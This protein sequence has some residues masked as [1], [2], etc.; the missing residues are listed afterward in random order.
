[1]CERTSW[2][3][4]HGRNFHSKFRVCRFCAIVSF[5]SV[6]HV[7]WRVWYGLKRQFSTWRRSRDPDT[8]ATWT[9]TWSV[10]AG[11]ETRTC[12]WT[13]ACAGWIRD[14][15]GII[16]EVHSVLG[17]DQT[18]C[19]ASFCLESSE[20]CFSYTE[21]CVSGHWTCLCCVHVTWRFDEGFITESI[22][23]LFSCF[24]KWWRTFL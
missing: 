13:C 2:C 1:M 6:L 15:T 24:C 22:F 19:N 14:K 16:A 12:C 4:E 3:S 5:H 17:I 23:I 10:H 9:W 21:V 18:D 8:G 20:F 11:A 7:S